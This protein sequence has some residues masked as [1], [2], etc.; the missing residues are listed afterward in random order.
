MFYSKETLFGDERDRMERQIFSLCR[1]CG[2]LSVVLDPAAWRLYEAIQ[3]G[4]GVYECVTVQ[5]RRLYLRGQSPQDVEDTKQ[6]IIFD[7]KT[8]EP[9]HSY[10]ELEADVYQKDYFTHV[11][12]DQ[13]CAEPNLSVSEPKRDSIYDPRA[14]LVGRANVKERIR[15]RK[16]IEGLPFV[17][18]ESGGVF[19]RCP[20]CGEGNYTN[21]HLE[22]PFDWEKR[23]RWAPFFTRAQFERIEAE[24]EKERV[25]WS[26]K[27]DDNL[28]ANAQRTTGGTFYRNCAQYD[29]ER[30]LDR[31]GAEEGLQRQKQFTAEC[32]AICAAPAVLR[33]K[34]DEKALIDHG[35]NIEKNIEFLTRRLQNLY[36]KSSTADGLARCAGIS[37]EFARNLEIAALEA[38][39]ARLQAVPEDDAVIGHYGLARPAEPEKLNRT[40]PKTPDYRAPGLFN[41]KKVLAENEQRRAAYEAALQ[42]YQSAVRAHEARQQEYRR[43]LEDFAQLLE[44][45]RRE[46]ITERAAERAALEKRLEQCCAAQEPCA[47]GAG[48]FLQAECRECETM[49]RG[50]YEARQELAGLKLIHPKYQN[51]LALATIAEYFETGRCT[52]LAGPDGAYNLYESE[53]RANRIIAQLDQVLDSLE[54]IK[55]NQYT[56]YCMLSQISRETAAIS[57][58]LTTAITSID[59]ISQHTAAIA[60]TNELIA[61]N[62]AKTAH[63]SRINAELTD[64]L[65]FMVALK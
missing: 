58:Q 60:E 53:L 6:S 24:H 52:T 56:A 19:V 45:K 38:N 10:P 13:Y 8:K 12:D 29:L 61:Y 22:G 40:E 44:Q 4:G 17:R 42:E 34:P 14:Y 2:T 32:E 48:S 65:G 39:I 9:N 41:K 59:A 57:S 46:W 5:K 63:Y 26:S 37:A 7:L 33:Q 15:I 36:A 18:K 3:A 11:F 28:V 43:E 1:K 25:G 51:L 16:S 30:Y 21:W 23:E 27:W 47:A 49:L 35:L 54:S 50:L 55:Q 64:A 31:L 62:T 20:C